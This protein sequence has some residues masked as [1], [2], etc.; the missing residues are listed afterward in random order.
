MR[1][2]PYQRRTCALIWDHWT[3]TGKSALAVLPTGA[4]K[5]VVA[6]AL[7]GAHLDATPGGHVLFVTH[8]TEVI[9]Q[10][11]RRFGPAFAEVGY[12]TGIWCASLGEKQWRPITVASVQSL[13]NLDEL[14]GPVTMVVLDECHGIPSSADSQYGKLLAKLPEG[15]P[16]LGLTATPWRLDGGEIFGADKLFHSITAKVEIEELIEAGHL[17]RPTMKGAERSERPDMQG[18]PT[19]AGDWN[20]AV[21]AS[22]VSEPQL[23]ERQID[24][25]LGRL[26]DR[27][28][29]VWFCVDIAHAEMVCRQLN[30]LDPK[31]AM[32]VHSQ[33]DRDTRDENLAKFVRGWTRHAVNVNVLTEG[34]DCPGVDGIVLLR[35]T[36]SAARY[37]QMVGRGLRPN[38]GKADCL[39]LD[40]AGIVKELGPI[41]N[42]LI[43][44]KNTEKG[45]API[46]MC[47]NCYEYVAMSTMTCP[48]CGHEWPARDKR[49]YKGNDRAHDG[50]ML[51]KRAYESREVT[52]VTAAHHNSKNG[53]ACLRLTY[54]HGFASTTTEY[55]MF[56]YPSTQAKAQ[57][58][59]AKL[60]V[61]DVR[62]IYTVGQAYQALMDGAEAGTLNDLSHIIVGRN[63]KYDEVVDRIAVGRPLATTV[64]PVL[65]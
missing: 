25:A 57:G 18:V 45:Q 23:V 46:K 55:L 59:L 65:R 54:H 42:P 2:R 51:S 11:A 4:G 38:E 14:P 48:D 34:W 16:V 10:T 36:K 52:K 6:Q 28:Q 37:V 41:T 31:G 35:P 1:L 19:T 22:R 9:G 50:D 53:N 12:P 43:T 63:G 32:V 39:V 5:T 47:P 3:A 33:M 40:Y 29:V 7:V 56:N 64:E 15:T 26:R 60:G 62:S 44:A 49:E 21:L 8:L 20:Q 61:R 17:V 58:V 27:S 13:A 24:D 30:L